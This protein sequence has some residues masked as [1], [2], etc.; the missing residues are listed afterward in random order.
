MLAAGDGIP[1]SYDCRNL[2]PPSSF[3]CSVLTDSTRS[4]IPRRVAWSCWACLKVRLVDV[5]WLLLCVVH[6]RPE[7]VAHIPPVDPAL[8]Y[9]F[10]G[11][12]LEHHLRHTPHL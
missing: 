12:S 11:S 3:S 8:H 10:E 6:T 1:N 9:S 5:G 2:F 7:L 4:T